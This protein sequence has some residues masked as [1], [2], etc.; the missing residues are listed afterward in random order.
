MLPYAKVVA[1]STSARVVL[2]QA[3][4]AY[5][6]ELI[7]RASVDV[8]LDT[9]AFPPA[10]DS[11]ANLQADARVE[12]GKRL[13]AAA[14]GL[15]TEGLSLD[16]VIVEADP[17]GAIVAETEQD[18]NTIIAISTHGR[19]GIGRWLMASVSDHVVRRTTSPV[20]VV[21]PQH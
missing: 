4:N 6:H 2:L 3:L 12:A 16:M 19:S 13:T 11:W 10:A 8:P 15:R 18:P 9:N 20:L 17:A 5:P 7:V 1:Q 21:R 14:D